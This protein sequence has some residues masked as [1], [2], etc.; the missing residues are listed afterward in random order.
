MGEMK[1]WNA[2]QCFRAASALEAT[3]RH[4][5]D[6]AKELDAAADDAGREAARALREAQERLLEARR[7][8]QAAGTQKSP[9]QLISR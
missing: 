2:Q 9:L 8:L 6:S 4:L 5:L 7:K 3:T 1:R